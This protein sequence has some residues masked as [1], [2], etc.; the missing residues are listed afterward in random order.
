MFWEVHGTFLL[1]VS[2][3]ATPNKTW[4]CTYHIL[5]QGQCGF[6]S[7]TS[8]VILVLVL[9]SITEGNGIVRKF[10]EMRKALAQCLTQFKCRI[11]FRYLVVAT[12]AASTMLFTLFYN[13]QCL[14]ISFSLH[15]VSRLV[16][17]FSPCLP[18][19]HAIDCSQTSHTYSR[20]VTSFSD[21]V[22]L[23]KHKVIS[24]FQQSYFI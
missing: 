8:S 7:F 24:V 9:L 14:T 12:V 4:W 15:S 13:S 17:L 21:I 3:L 22:W 6:K 19:G 20:G 2:S 23:L 16:V 1:I 18:P 10:N 11:H 5:A